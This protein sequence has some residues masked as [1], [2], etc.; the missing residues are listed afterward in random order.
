MVRIFNDV[1]RVD[2]SAHQIGHIGG[3]LDYV[4]QTVRRIAD[5]VVRSDIEAVVTDARDSG[6]RK[7]KDPFVGLLVMMKCRR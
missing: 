3:R 7:N 5:E 1:G 2:L 6:A 4:W